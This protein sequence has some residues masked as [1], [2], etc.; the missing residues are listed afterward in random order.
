MQNL[1]KDNEQDDVNESSRDYIYNGQKISYEEYKE[2]SDDEKIK[3][4]EEAN[5]RYFESSL[6]DEQ[7]PLYAEIKIMTK[8]LNEIKKQ[9]EEYIKNIRAKYQQLCKTQDDA[10]K[11][12]TK[13][14]ELSEFVGYSQHETYKSD[15]NKNM[16]CITHRRCYEYYPFE[17]ISKELLDKYDC[18]YEDDGDHGHFTIYY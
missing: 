8:Q 5:E 6:T 7:K 11:C 13:Y 12:I 2:L 9:K 15:D 17:K 1:T 14:L 16:F 4:E 10:I 18:T 3:I